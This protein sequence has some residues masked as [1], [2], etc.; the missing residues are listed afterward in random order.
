MK[1]SVI[2]VTF[3]SAS[4][5]ETTIH[6]LLCQTY[7]NVEF[8]IIDGLSTDRTLDIINYYRNKIDI[9]ISEKDNGIYDA[10]NKGIG[11]ATGDVIS[12]LNSDD[13]YANSSLLEVVANAFKRNQIDC[14]YGDLIYVNRIN[15]NKILRYWKSREFKENL[16]CTGWHPPH[17]TFFVKNECYQ[18]YSS[19][20]LDFKIA[21]DY[22]LMLRFL[23]KYLLKSFYL[24]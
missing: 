9:F 20:N 8:I 5:I 23:E 1:I 6:S 14:L 22:E 18:K 17:P 19:F 2:T 7:K 13:M 3:N 24:P 16:F 15:T 10:M 4:T 12:I 11:L 21:A